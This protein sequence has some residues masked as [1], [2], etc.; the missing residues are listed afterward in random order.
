VESAIDFCILE[1]Q[2]AM[3]GFSVPRDRIHTEFTQKKKRIFLQTLNPDKK[4]K[5]LNPEPCTPYF[6]TK[7][8]GFKKNPAFL[9]ENPDLLSTTS[10]DPR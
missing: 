4:P 5:T 1:R 2:S 7:K 6:K 10:R 9:E 3:S 8:K